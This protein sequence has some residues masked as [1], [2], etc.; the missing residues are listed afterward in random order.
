M[1][2]IFHTLDTWCPYLIR[3]H[4]QIKIDH[5]ILRYSLEQHFSSPKKHKWVTKI[6]GHA[7]EII[8]NKG[9]ENVVANAL[10]QNMRRK[11]PYMP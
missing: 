2:T 10:S 8:Y 3:R 11:G 4:F 6:L 1:M 7:Y 9:K 5:I